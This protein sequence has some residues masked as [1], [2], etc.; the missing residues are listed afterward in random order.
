MV[1]TVFFLLRLFLQFGSVLKIILSHKF[2]NKAGI[3]YL[4][5]S[6][7]K[8]PFSFFNYVVFNPEKHSIK[9]LELILEHEKVHARQFHSAD[10]LFVNLATCIIWFNPLVW[11]YK[12]AIEQNLEFIADRETVNNN[13]D[14]KQ[15]Q[16]ALVQVSIADFT[17]ALTNH[18]YKSFIKKRIL[19]LNKKSSTQSP[20]WKLGLVMPLILAFMLLFNV[21]T[22]AQVVETKETKNIKEAPAPERVEELE[23]EE[24]IEL[25]DELAT[26][27]EVNIE[28]KE[29]PQEN[30]ILRK[31]PRSENPS[32]NL[33]KDLLYVLNGKSYKARK[34][35][36]KYIALES[37]PKILTGE[38]AV[39]QYGDNAENGAIIIPKADIIRNFDKV[40][41]E[42]EGRTEFSGRYIMVDEYGKPNY[43]RLNSSTSAPRQQR[44]FQ[45]GNHAQVRVSPAMNNHYVV[46]SSSPKWNSDKNIVYEFKTDGKKN[47]K[48]KNKVRV[49]RISNDSNKISI[50]T[51]EAEPIYVVD[52]EIQTKDYIQ[53]IEPEEIASINV[54]KGGMAIK[55]YGNKAKNG[56]IIIKT[57]EFSGES[58]AAI[59]QIKNSFTPEQIEALKNEVKAKT[60]YTLELKDIKR[61]ED[62]IITNIN[63]RFYN[64]KSMVNSQYNNENG[65]PDILVGLRPGGG[66]TISASE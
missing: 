8:L 42:A 41:D 14:L 7:T 28:I 40:M 21:R 4:K 62:G 56:V 36:G 9:D 45:G 46:R 27:E 13:A 25:D 10:I 18:F 22:E 51:Q 37:R 11:L 50:N 39:S 63:V 55:E 59:F 66:L 30:W 29:A 52:E 19:M 60:Q 15:Y 34:L 23:I 64:S 6:D 33:G 38:K 35:K 31:S 32:A 26:N 48:N 2:E 47:G 49:R 24:V 43:V 5:T 53:L 58:K 16:H 54:L 61:N 44:I 17:P 12:K 3:N 65:I 57:K 1:I 20:A